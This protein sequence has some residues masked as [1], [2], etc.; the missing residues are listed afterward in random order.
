MIYAHL[1]YSLNQLKEPTMATT[2]AALHILNPVTQKEYKRSKID[3][4]VTSQGSILTGDVYT[5][6][7][8][9][10][11]LVKR[12]VELQPITTLRPAPVIPAAL[13]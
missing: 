1:H 11:F 5:E 3:V 9:V 2:S 13:V 8:I 6:G 4:T 12:K 10:I 7:D